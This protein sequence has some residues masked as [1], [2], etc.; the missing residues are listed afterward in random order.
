M[1]SRGWAPCGVIHSVGM[2]VVEVLEVE[3]PAPRMAL[4]LS[5]PADMRRVRPIQV[6]KVLEVTLH[7]RRQPWP[8]PTV[9][10]PEGLPVRYVL[11]LAPDKAL[12]LGVE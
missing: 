5:C 6:G 1:D 11:G 7:A 9:A 2:I 4:I 3:E 8:K 12:P 10:P